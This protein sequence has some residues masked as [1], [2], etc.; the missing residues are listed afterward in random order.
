M[1]ILRFP[2]YRSSVHGLPVQRDLPTGV[3][4]CKLFFLVF[5]SVGVV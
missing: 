5:S 3:G 1:V 4:S 2:G